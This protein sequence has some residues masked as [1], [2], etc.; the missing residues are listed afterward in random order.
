MSKLIFLKLGVFT[1]KR[2]SIHGSDFHKM[3]KLMDTLTSENIEF[4][5]CRING[6]FLDIPDNS[7]EK[8]EKIAN[9]LK[10][11]IKQVAITEI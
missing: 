4:D 8:Y 5:V 2:Y 6:Y 10:F 9:D 11:I 7:V 1:M 3:K